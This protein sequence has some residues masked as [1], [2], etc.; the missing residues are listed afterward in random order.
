MSTK[1]T[2]SL[3]AISNRAWELALSKGAPWAKALSISSIAWCTLAAS[4]SARGVAT[5]PLSVRTS[6]G[7]ASKV[8]SRPSV[9]LMAGCVMP[10]RSAARVTW[11]SLTSAVRQRSR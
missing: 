8:R 2:D 9:A 10:M 7:S 1:A 4:S 3:A 6:S 11:A 5:M